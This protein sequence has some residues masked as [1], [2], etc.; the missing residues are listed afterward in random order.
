MPK[1]IDERTQRAI[2]ERVF[3]GCVVGITRLNRGREIFAFG[4][5]TYESGSSTMGEHT[6]FDVASITKSIPTASL[7]LLLIDQGLM[8]LTDTVVT[9]VPELH[10]DHGATIEDLLRYR[11]HGIQ[12][13][14]LRSLTFEEIRTHALEHGFDGAPGEY[15]Y[16]NLPA[17]VLGMVVERVG[18]ASIASLAQRYFFGPLCMESTT[19]FPTPSDCPPTEIDER[20]E[21][22]GFPHDESAYRFARARRSV[23]HAGLFSSVSDLL[24]FLDMLLRDGV[25]TD[26]AEK[27]LGWQLNQPWFMGRECRKKTFGKTGFTGTSV[28]VDREWGMG[29]VILSN[30][31]WPK[32]P[33]D[34]SSIHSAINTFRRDIAEIVCAYR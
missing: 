28:V 11:V 6:I 10:N 17:F 13:S 3:P 30:R 24:H 2:E 7:A 14:K 23:G 31:T 5:F 21:V 22:Q 4:N 12:L 20:G 18:G 33:A 34:S 26:G 8:R 16:T 29:L 25:I 9:Y 32:R 27:G 19:F 15:V 1:R